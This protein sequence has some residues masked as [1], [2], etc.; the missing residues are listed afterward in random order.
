MKAMIDTFSGLTDRFIFA[1]FSY[2]A[3]FAIF[4]LP[5]TGWWSLSL[6]H[7]HAEVVF[8][9][10]SS[11]YCRKMIISKLRARL[12]YLGKGA[13]LCCLCFDLVLNLAAAGTSIA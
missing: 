6:F 5:G 13:E 4:P 3:P 7:M 12:L 11:S 10:E 9:D 8:V 2:L 1:I